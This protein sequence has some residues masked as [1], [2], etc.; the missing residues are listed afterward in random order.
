LYI[1]INIILLRTVLRGA[2]VY[3][4]RD[5]KSEIV[6]G[7]ERKKFAV[8]RDFAESKSWKAKVDFVTSRLSN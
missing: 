1:I 3:K 4:T 8:Q 5:A 7:K 2:M 6:A